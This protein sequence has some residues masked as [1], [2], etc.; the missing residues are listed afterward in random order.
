MLMQIFLYLAHFPASGEADPGGSKG[1]TSFY[2]AGNGLGKTILI[3]W[4]PGSVH[5][6][7]YGKEGSLTISVSHLPTRPV[8]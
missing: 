1:V 7:R 8:E 3:C 2:S 5:K 4:G 6:R